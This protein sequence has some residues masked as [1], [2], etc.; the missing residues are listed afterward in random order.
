MPKENLMAKRLAKIKATGATSALLQKIKKGK[1]P[2][3]KGYTESSISLAEIAVAVVEYA[4]LHVTKQPNNKILDPQKCYMK[5]AD[6][7]GLGNN[8]RKAITTV[9]TTATATSPNKAAK[10]FSTRVSS[11]T[12][13][14]QVDST[15]HLPSSLPSSKKT[16]AVAKKV[17]KD[18]RSKENIVKRRVF[19]V[20]HILENTGIC[21]RV[22]PNRAAGYYYYGLKSLAKGL[23]IWQGAT[24]SFSAQH[25]KTLRHLKVPIL[26]TISYMFLRVCINTNDK[27]TTL[28]EAA[29]KIFKELLFKLK[30]SKDNNKLPT[31]KGVERRLYD[32]VSVLATVGVITR[33][34]KCITI[35]YEIL[36]VKSCDAH[37]KQAMLKTKQNP[38]K[39]RKPRTSEEVAL[40]KFLKALQKS[41]P[42]SKKSITYTGKYKNFLPTKVMKKRSNGSSIAKSLEAKNAKNDISDSSKKGSTSSKKRNANVAELVETVVDSN[43][44]SPKKLKRAITLSSMQKKRKVTKKKKY[45]TVKRAF[46]QNAGSYTIGTNVILAY[47]KA[48]KIGVELDDVKLFVTA[49]TA[50][51]F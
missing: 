48:E 6:N 28:K 47:D 5:I 21:K 10:K 29:G 23:K 42:G 14:T 49:M 51:C 31:Q 39:R 17:N 46:Q 32:V 11:P 50:L 36:K 33:T 20:L 12:S 44:A 40:D 34:R 43:R 30:D 45:E 19:D 35:P 3:S 18:R 9:T 24:R 37:A 41:N 13:I 38:Q 22:S 26:S 25:E 2:A 8:R 4:E 1:A 16:T 7:I 27:S 15:S